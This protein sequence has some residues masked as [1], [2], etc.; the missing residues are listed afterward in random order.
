MKENKDTISL[1]AYHIETL[2]GS[3]IFNFFT[4]A[5]TH[6][7]ALRNLEKNSWDYKKLVKADKDLT[8]K[9]KIVNP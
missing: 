5:K 1:N 2:D 6:K 3:A 7:Q 9:I 8:I 4:Q